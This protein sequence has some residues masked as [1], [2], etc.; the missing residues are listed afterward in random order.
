[1]SLR[2]P[3]L[4]FQTNILAQNAALVQQS[5]A[6]AESMQL[7]SAALAKAVS[8]FKIDGKASAPASTAPRRR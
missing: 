8:V 2:G 1:L 6:A 4:A 3:I 5:A 7:Q